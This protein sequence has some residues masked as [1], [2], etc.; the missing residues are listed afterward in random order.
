VW[1][2]GPRAWLTAHAQVVVLTAVA[3]TMIANAPAVFLQQAE[4]VAGQVDMYLT[5]SQIHGGA[6]LNYTQLARNLQIDPNFR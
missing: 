5:P 6:F 1:R 4:T 2:D 3:F